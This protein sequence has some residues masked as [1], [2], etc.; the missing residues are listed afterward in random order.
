MSKLITKYGKSFTILPN[1]FIMNPD[2]SSDAKCLMLVLQQYAW[3][4]NEVFPGVKSLLYHLGWSEHIYYKARKELEDK[5]FIEVHQQKENGRFAHNVYILN[6]DHLYEISV[7]PNFKDQNVDHPE[8]SPNNTNIYNK[9]NNNN[10]TNI[11]NK[12]KALFPK[13]D[14]YSKVI[15]YLNEK[16]NS[17]FKSTS[18]ETVRLIDI[19]VKEGYTLDDFMYVLDVKYDEWIGTE[20]I[21]YYTPSTL[22]KLEKF[23]KYVNQKP[24]VKSKN[25]PPASFKGQEHNTINT[26]NRRRDV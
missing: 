5:G 10:N 6:P 8:T 14:I 24:I 21:Q 2:V 4:N 17:K 1:T 22:F 11:Y 15:N 16:N 19:L 20:F 13:N 3:T 25:Q 23:E 18:K 9:T 26:S 7:C 12:Q